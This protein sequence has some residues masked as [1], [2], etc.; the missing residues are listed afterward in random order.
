M[1]SPRAGDNTFVSGLYSPHYH[2]NGLYEHLFFSRDEVSLVHAIW[3]IRKQTMWQCFKT[4]MCIKIALFPII[5]QNLHAE[6]NDSLASSLHWWFTC[7]V[8]DIKQQNIHFS[9]VLTEQT[10]SWWPAETSVWGRNKFQHFLC[11]SFFGRYRPGS[12]IFQWLAACESRDLEFYRNMSTNL[13]R[14]VKFQLKNQ[15]RS[16]PDSTAHQHNIPWTTRWTP[17]TQAILPHPIQEEKITHKYKS[18]NSRQ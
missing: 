11:Y 7:G 8:C 2:F 13:E 17:T 14:K 12:S 4:V 5:H 1:F 15:P 10:W 3:S 16:A 9:A 6:T 18:K